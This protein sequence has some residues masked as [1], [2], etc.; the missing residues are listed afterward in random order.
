MATADFP[1][2]RRVPQ[3]KSISSRTKLGRQLRKLRQKI[4]KSG[5]RLLTPDEIDAELMSRRGDR[6][7]A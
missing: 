1:Q 2:K 4:V 7:K 6:G 3:D 5:V